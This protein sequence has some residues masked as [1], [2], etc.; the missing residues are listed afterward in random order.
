[1]AES[2]TAAKA[3]ARAPHQ[4]TANRDSGHLKSTAPVERSVGG[5]ARHASRGGE[6]KDADLE[7]WN[8]V[9]RPMDILPPP[10]SEPDNIAHWT[11][12]MFL[13]ARK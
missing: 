3:A 12:A 11:R 9:D 13:D 10:P 5:R 4:P 7:G 8:F 2:L 6:R 1:M